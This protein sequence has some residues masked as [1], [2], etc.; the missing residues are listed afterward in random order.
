M[1]YIFDYPF[2]LCSLVIHACSPLLFIALA[3]Y[4]LGGV[5]TNEYFT[6]SRQGI[7]L[8]TDRFD[9]LE[10]LDEFSRSF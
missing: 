4:V 10:Q 5:R 6:E 7:P 9:S 3:E 1:S 2:I 8:I